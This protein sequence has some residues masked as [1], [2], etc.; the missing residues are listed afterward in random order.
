[1]IVLTSGPAGRVAVRLLG[2][3]PGDPP[4]PVVVWTVIGNM[5]ASQSVALLYSESSM[6]LS[7]FLICSYFSFSFALL[8]RCCS[9]VTTGARAHQCKISGCNKGTELTISTS[10][11]SE[12]KLMTFDNSTTT[13]RSHRFAILYMGPPQLVQVW[14]VS[15]LKNSLALIYIMSSILFVSK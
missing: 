8:G 4:L 10:T 15:M 3:G 12:I 14:D 13:T 9:E 11:A 5:T 1:M 2:W 6:C 7:N